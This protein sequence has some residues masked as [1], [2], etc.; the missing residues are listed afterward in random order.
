MSN[1]GGRRLIYGFLFGLLAGL[2]LLNA[3]FALAWISVHSGYGGHYDVGI[4]RLS[5]SPNLGHPVHIVIR[6]GRVGFFLA[7]CGIAAA[8]VNV[9][10]GR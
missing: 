3:G 2:V 4:F 1:F 8:A 7:M 9:I 6:E 10:R 5:Y